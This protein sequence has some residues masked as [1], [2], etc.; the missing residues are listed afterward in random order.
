MTNL[1]RRSLMSFSLSLTSLALAGA[2]TTASFS[3]AAQAGAPTEGQQYRK[4]E[5]RQPTSSGDKKIEIIEFFWFA[6][7]HCNALDPAL[8]AWLKKAP[9]D[10]SFKRVHVNFGTVATPDKRTDMHQ[11]LFLTLEAMGLNAAQNSAVFTAIHADRKKLLTR[12]D[13]LEWAKSRNLDMAKFTATFDD[14]F[15]MTRKQTAAFQLQAAYKVEGVPHFGVDGQYITSP[16]MAKSEAGFFNTLDTLIQIARK[17][18]GTTGVTTSAK[19]TSKV[20]AKPH[21]P[22]PLTAS[23]AEAALK[24]AAKKYNA[25]QN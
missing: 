19:A 1:T 18:R 7:P 10:V 20:L 2:L 25:A 4:L 21:N 8:E 13:V 3:A 9:A 16:A 17:S 6:C 5:T 24:V 23:S 22:P 14:R 11:R 15:T 12:E